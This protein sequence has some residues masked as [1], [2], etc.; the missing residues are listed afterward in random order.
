[1]F[2][3]TFA[4]KI[5]YYNVMFESA[6]L[7]EKDVY[8]RALMGETS[9][10][11]NEI[12]DKINEKYEYWDK[13]K[14]KHLPSGYTSQQLWSH[15]KAS[16]ALG[17]KTI[18]VKYGI[19][20]SVTNKMQQMCHDF[21]MIFGSFWESDTMPQTAD[22]KRYLAS[23]LMEEAIF[24]SQMEG[25]VTTRAVAKEM[26]KKGISPQNKSQQMISNNYKTICYIVEHKDEPLT[27]ENIRLIHSLMTNKTLKNEEDVGRFRTEQDDVVVENQLTGDVVHTPPLASDLAEFIDDLCHFFNNGNGKVFIHPIIRGIIVHFMIAYMHP[28]V[29]GNGRTARALFYWYMLK[30]K[31]W[32]TEYMSIS[33]VIANSKRSYEDAFLF[34][35]LDGCDI[36]Y[37]VV[38]NLRVLDISFRQLK[39]YIEKKQKEKQKANMF[40]VTNRNINE[41]QAQIIQY[42]VEHPT[43]VVTVK[44]MQNRFLVA[45]MTARKDLADLVDKGYLVEIAI[46]KVKMGYIKSDAF[47][48]LVRV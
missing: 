13:V 28:F 15:V 38:Y 17:A 27:A 14:Y 39:D 42:F 30:E 21:D 29:D 37:F 10:E 46:N 26:L 33:R 7:I 9:E 47:D 18:W 32:L 41:R 19:K 24:S 36:G 40:I 45:S 16:R 43:T 48:E 44:D 23:S 22:K 35:E 12:V 25:A 1:M 8:I 6:P 31:Y 11:A 4:G 34:T 2:F 3:C 5:K 20:L